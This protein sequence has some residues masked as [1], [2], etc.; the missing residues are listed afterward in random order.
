MDS[1]ED[2]RSNNMGNF[3]ALGTYCQETFSGLPTWLVLIPAKSFLGEEQVCFYP[4]AVDPFIFPR[5]SARPAFGSVNLR[6][7]YASSR[8]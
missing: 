5:Y 8:V 1:K 3:K 2:V 7:A 4:L 6:V